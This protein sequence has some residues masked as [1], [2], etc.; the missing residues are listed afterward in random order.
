MSEKYKTL[1]ELYAEKPQST[2]DNDEILHNCAHCGAE[3]CDCGSD[4]DCKQCCTGCGCD[5]EVD[6]SDDDVDDSDGDN[7]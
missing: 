2:D 4:C 6:T 5:T 7:D 1:T 3:S